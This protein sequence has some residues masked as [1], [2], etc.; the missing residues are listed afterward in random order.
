[1]GKGIA[2]KDI[3]IQ[4]IT[5]FQMNDN[6]GNLTNYSLNQNVFVLSS[7]IKKIE[8]LALNPE[9]FA[10]RGLLLQNSNL[11]Y[12]YSKLPELKKQLFQKLQRM[13]LTAPKRFLPAP[14]P[15]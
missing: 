4:P 10:D 7:D 2:E 3:N 15:A 11:A 14:K 9:F 5:S 13:P 12:L 1:V 8:E 6:Y